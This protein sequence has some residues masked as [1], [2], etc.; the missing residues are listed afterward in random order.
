MPL[1]SAPTTSG[2]TKRAPSAQES[3]CGP[4]PRARA[5][6]ADVFPPPVEHDDAA[7]RCDQL[8]DP[9]ALRLL[10]KRRVRGVLRIG[11]HDN[12]LGAAAAPAQSRALPRGLGVCPG[13]TLAERG[14]R[15]F[16]PTSSKLV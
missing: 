1:A 5:L 12:L 6:A 4:Q 13:S 9:L 2:E 16:R 7:A 15:A 14:V 11:L 10:L 3:S 8:D